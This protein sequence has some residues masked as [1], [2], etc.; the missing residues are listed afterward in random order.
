M[1]DGA[2]LHGIERWTLG[3]GAV[4]TIGAFICA[5]REVG[6]AVSTGAGLMAL[7]AIAMRRVG[8]KIFRIMQADA[9]GN[10]PSALR[11][12]ILFNLKMAAVFGAV[13]IAVRVLHAHPI[14]LVIG[15]SVYPLAA[16]ASTLTYVAPPEPTLR[17]ATTP[18]EDHHG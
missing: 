17:P 13:Y 7:N 6:L 15:L 4:V 14:G 5:G 10:R 11:A 16:V 12:V 9:G 8:E 18:S 1:T 3:I 2:R